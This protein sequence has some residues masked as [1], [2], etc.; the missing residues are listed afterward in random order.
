MPNIFSSTMHSLTLSAAADHLGFQ[1]S[2]NFASRRSFAIEREE[3]FHFTLGDWGGEPV[4]GRFGESLLACS[5]S[6]S[7]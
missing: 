3:A 1:L 2:S 4:S 7:R 6:N 5:F